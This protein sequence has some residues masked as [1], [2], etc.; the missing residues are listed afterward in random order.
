[1]EEGASE[2]HAETIL[3]I[4]LRVFAGWI[5]GE[6]MTINFTVRGEPI[7]QGSMK[8][9]MPKG[10]NY[11][12]ITS[13]NPKLKQWRRLVQ[14]QAE[15]AVNCEDPAGKSVPIRVELM[16]YFERPKGNKALD[17]TT[18]PDLDKCARAILDSLTG[19]CFEDDSQVTELHAL[20]AYGSPRVEIRVEE[21][22]QVASFPMKHQVPRDEQL[23]F[24][25]L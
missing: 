21:A 23:P 14:Q 10:A 11:P 15:I 13:D 5:T 18:R 9:F 17:K 16:F 25:T 22:D 4:K 19:V 6:N 7:P 12:I 3:S 8:A 1:M 24:S 2:V 20:K